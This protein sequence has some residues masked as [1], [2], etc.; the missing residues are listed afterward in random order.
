MGDRVEVALFN[1][2]D[3]LTPWGPYN[4]AIGNLD[5]PV[6]RILLRYG[7][8]LME[9]PAYIAANT[10]IR[11]DRFMYSRELRTGI[12]GGEAEFLA[13]DAEDTLLGLVCDQIDRANPDLPIETCQ[14]IARDIIHQ[15]VRERT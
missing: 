6:T 13:W 3:Q 5:K 7:T 11:L 2:D 4:R 9:V 12:T 14:Q 15:L 10:E 1:G 8:D